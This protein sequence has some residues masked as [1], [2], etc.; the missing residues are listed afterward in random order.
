ML[1]IVTTREGRSATV[2]DNTRDA[3]PAGRGVACEGAAE[4]AP[5]AG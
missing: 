4:V 3:F 2:I 5:R 1:T